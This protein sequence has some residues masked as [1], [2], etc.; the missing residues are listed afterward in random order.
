M[1]TI[2]TTLRQL[3]HSISKTKIWKKLSE[4]K[5]PIKLDD[6]LM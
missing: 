3:S 2:S 6:E 5:R 4:N 1:A